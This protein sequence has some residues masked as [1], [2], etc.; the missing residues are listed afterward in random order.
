[1]SPVPIPGAGVGGTGT[2]IAMIPVSQR[3]W[4]RMLAVACGGWVVLALTRTERVAAAIG[5]SAS[6][7]RAL[8]VRDL[9]SAV[10][11]AAASDPRPA[12]GARVFFDLADSARYGRGRPTLLASTLG[13]AAIGAV[14][15][16]ARP[17]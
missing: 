8:A 2:V 11:L 4:A 16:L 13:F 17:G 5:A 1:M 7:V 6:E 10:T 14:G 3:A 15:L 12:I 9:A